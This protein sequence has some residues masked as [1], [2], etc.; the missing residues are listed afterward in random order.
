MLVTITYI[1]ACASFVGS[2]VFLCVVVLR[3]VKRT[4]VERALIYETLLSI[5]AKLD[6]NE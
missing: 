4:R 6:K 2:L 5:C 3:N 1:I